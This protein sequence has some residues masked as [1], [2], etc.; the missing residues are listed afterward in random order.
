M[1]LYIVVYLVKQNLLLWR[2]E[3][4]LRLF[5]QEAADSLGNGGGKEAASHH[6]EDQPNQERP[7][8]GF[9]LVCPYIPDEPYSEYDHEYGKAEEY[10]ENK[11][12]KD[13]VHVPLLDFLRP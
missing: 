12:K 10:T 13:S 11:P 2:N 8:E 6:Y 9:G 1:I 4:E 5:L 3:A 7:E